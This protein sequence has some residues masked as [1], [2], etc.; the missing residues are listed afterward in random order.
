MEDD[1]MSFELHFV[2]SAGDL[3]HWSCSYRTFEQLITAVVAERALGARDDELFVSC[4]GGLSPQQ[5]DELLRRGA[6]LI[7]NRK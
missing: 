4:P 7:T 3:S 5:N 1:P 6:R 2:P